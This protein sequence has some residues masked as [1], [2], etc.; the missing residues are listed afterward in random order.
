ERN[1]QQ[2]VVDTTVV[3]P[4]FR[5]FSRV[6]PTPFLGDQLTIRVDGQVSSAH[7][8]F[9]RYSHDGSASFGPTTSTRNQ[10]FSYPSNWTPQRARADQGLVGVTS[11]VTSR[12]VNDVRVSMFVIDSSETAATDHE[13]RGCLGIG[14][15]D[16]VIPGAGLEIGR[17][18]ASSNA[19]RRYHV[20][21]SLSWQGSTHRVRTGVDWEHD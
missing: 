5:G 4:A 19:G 16:I 7:T 6:T 15:P 13:C 20:N 8:A 1:D 21:D 12:L 2:S 10:R 17:S 18:F 9:V 11:V 3:S 14:A